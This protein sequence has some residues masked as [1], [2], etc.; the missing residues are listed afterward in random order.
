MSA[1]TEL[2]AHE[3]VCEERYKNI[4]RRLDGLEHK[5]DNLD[6][7]IDNFKNDIYKL[8][9]GSSVSI[10]I[11]LITVAVTILTKH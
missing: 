5:F 6:S 7:K 11:C 3:Q 8:L 9:I 2:A 1:L 4:N 10:I